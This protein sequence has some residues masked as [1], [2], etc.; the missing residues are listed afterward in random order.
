MKFPFSKRTLVKAKQF[1]FPTDKEK[2]SQDHANAILIVLSQHE[3][4]NQSDILLHLKD[5]MIKDREET[6]AELTKDLEKL[7]KI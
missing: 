7:R 6:I 1:I 5:A 2:T 3:T 4:A